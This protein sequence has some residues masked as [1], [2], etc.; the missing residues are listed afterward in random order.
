MHSVPHTWPACACIP[1]GTTYVF[2]SHRDTYSLFARK[3]YRERERERERERDIPLLPVPA[4]WSSE[5]RTCSVLTISAGLIL[6]TGL[7][8]NLNEFFLLKEGL[9]FRI[10][11]ATKVATKKSLECEGRIK[12]V[13]V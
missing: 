10:R 1:V 6:S 4:T 12:M 5:E 13:T 2:P 11:G 3:F 7:P 9:H 8:V